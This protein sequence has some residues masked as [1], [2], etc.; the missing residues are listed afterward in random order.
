MMSLVVMLIDDDISGKVDYI[1]M[2][3]LVVKLIN[4]DVSGK[5]DW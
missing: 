2:I 4:N 1:L 3:L 5:V